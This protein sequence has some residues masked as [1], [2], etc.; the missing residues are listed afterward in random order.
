MEPELGPVHMVRVAVRAD[1]LAELARRL[2]LPLR[3]SDDGYIV[4]AMLKGLF[5]DLAPKPFAV[6]ETRA[7]WVSVLGYTEVSHEALSDWAQAYA[8]PWF[9]G[10]CDW[11]NLSSKELPTSFAPG[12]RLGFALRMCPVVR[13][14][15]DSEFA[16]RGAEVD[17]FLDHCWRV[18]PDVAVARADV[19]RGWLA[20]ELGRRGG[21]TL[22]EFQMEGFRRLRLLRRTQEEQRRSRGVERPD[23]FVK[24][25]LEV[26]ESE[27]FGALLRRGLGRHRSFGFGMLLLRPVEQGRC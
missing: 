4:H 13:K 18:G 19:Y 26:T 1:R 3:D 10:A 24:G 25:V 7:R 14:A 20:G 15:K 16:R 22:V 23:V 21:A 27:A 6:Q 11:E 2:R 5:G 17:A 12:R 9:H 8:D